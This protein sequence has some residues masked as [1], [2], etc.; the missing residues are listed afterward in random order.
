MR[1]RDIAKIAGKEDLQANLALFAG[2]LSSVG[3]ALSSANTIVV[4]ACERLQLDSTSQPRDICDKLILELN[5]MYEQLPWA[6]SQ[7]SVT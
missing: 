6:V 1:L 5:R 7:L 2:R 3:E 4:S